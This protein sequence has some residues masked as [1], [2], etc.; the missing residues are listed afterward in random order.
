MLSKGGAKVE[1]SVLVSQQCALMAKRANGVPVGQWLTKDLPMVDQQLGNGWLM[2]GHRVTTSQQ[3]VLLA[4]KANGS[5][6][7]TAQST[8][9]RAG[10]CSPPLL[11]TVEVPS[12][13]PGPVLGS[14]A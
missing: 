3:C 13:A 11:C 8:T 4:M 1:H 5:P 6:W 10:R 12:G 9:S 2:V 14:P 7:G